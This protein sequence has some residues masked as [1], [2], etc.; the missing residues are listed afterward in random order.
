MKLDDIKNMNIPYLARIEL[1]INAKNNTTSKEIRG[2]RIE[3]AMGYFIELEKYGEYPT[4]KY[5][6][7]LTHGVDNNNKKIIVPDFS[8]KQGCMTVLLDYIKILEP[9]EEQ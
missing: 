4:I 2:D 5:V 3:T 7:S 8:K 6:T 1:G 9:K